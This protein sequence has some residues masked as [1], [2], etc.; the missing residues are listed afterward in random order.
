[1]QDMNDLRRMGMMSDEMVEEMEKSV[2]KFYRGEFDAV[3]RRLNKVDGM[4]TQERKA[5]H[6]P[7]HKKQPLAK[8]MKK[9]Q[10]KNGVLV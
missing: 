9:R 2:H 4:P 3:E 5:Q 10:R 7:R 1:M 6:T 8:N